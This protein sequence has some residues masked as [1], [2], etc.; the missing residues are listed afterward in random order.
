MRDAPLGPEHVATS[1]QAERRTEA[2]GDRQPSQQQQLG[3]CEGGDRYVR[4][5][6]KPNDPF[7]TERMKFAGYCSGGL[8]A[9]SHSLRSARIVTPADIH[10]LS[11]AAA[12]IQLRRSG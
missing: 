12:T 11:V 1:R 10:E 3:R 4:I 9:P 8:S 7:E 6:P 5:G 2:V